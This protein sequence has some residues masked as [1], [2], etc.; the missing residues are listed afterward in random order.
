M[1]KNDFVNRGY[2]KFTITTLPIIPE[3]TRFGIEQKILSAASGNPKELALA[4][5]YG[6]L[7]AK[8][9]DHTYIFGAEAPE[10]IKEYAKSIL[11][12]LYCYELGEKRMNEDRLK[13]F[14]DA[15]REITGLTK[16]KLPG[17]VIDLDPLARAIRIKETE[18]K[19]RQGE[20]Y[21]ERWDTSWL[22]PKKPE[23]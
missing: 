3:A 17:T 16:S 22:T 19:W 10:H 13:Y 11:K 18:D 20:A 23:T 21:N 9:D 12:E 14:E 4:I 8:D 2:N 7:L 15:G 6:V 5:F 1:R